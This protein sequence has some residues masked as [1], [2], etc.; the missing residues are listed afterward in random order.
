MLENRIN[1]ITIRNYRSLA[2]VTVDLEDLTVLVG[3]NGSGKS[4]FLDAL[5]FV[6]DVLSANLDWALQQRGGFSNILSKMSENHADVEI[7][8]NLS[9]TGQQTEYGFTFGI[10][11]QQGPVIK[12]EICRFGQFGYDVIFGKNNSVSSNPPLPFTPDF[13]T[14]LPKVLIGTRWGLAFTGL[15][16]PLH[17]FL[18][19]LHV[20]SA[21]PTDTLRNAQN[22]LPHA[23]LQEDGSNLASTLRDFLNDENNSFRANLFEDFSNIIPGVDTARP[24]SV[25]QLGNKLLVMVNHSN[26]IGSLDL[27]SESDGTIRVL[28]LLTS[29]Y[30]PNWLSLIG[31]E[32]PELMIHP[33]AL[34]YLADVIWAASHRSQI[35]I[36]THS[37]DLISRFAANSLR[38]VELIEG[39]TKIDPLR[40]DQRRII[41]EKIFKG[42]DLLRLGGLARG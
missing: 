31:I 16:A 13:I 32:E 25:E 38:L 36:S 34:A 35:I 19:D 5:R 18:T 26:G 37:P 14:S 4:N 22:Q 21:L 28:T 29:L 8:M 27:G 42:G 10:D 23:R 33:G 17:G 24:I 40:E 15:W 12:H 9:L 2:D 3:P 1:S 39:K 41:E 6:R 30:D 7:M 20:Y 11:Q